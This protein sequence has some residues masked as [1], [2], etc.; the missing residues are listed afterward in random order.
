MSTPAQHPAE[1]PHNAAPA[2]GD[3]ATVPVPA[4]GG[5]GIDIVRSLNR[6]RTVA[7]LAALFIVLA[8]TP[9]AWLKGKPKYGATAVIFVSPRFLANLRDSVE[10][11]LQSDQQYRQYVQQNARTINRFDILVEALR[12]AGSGNPFLLK[13]SEPVEH[14]AERLQ[15]AL[16]I[17]PVPDTYQ[18]AVSLEGDK[19]AGL[20]EL[21]NAVVNRFLAKAKA[22]AFYASDE[23]I[24]NLVSD[25]TRI[26]QDMAAKQ[27]RRL[28]ITQEL[29]VSSFTNNFVNPYDHLLVGAREALAAAR[30]QNIQS[31]AAFAAYDA[32]QRAAGADSLRSLAEQ[33]VARD[34]ALTSLTASQSARRTQLMTAMSGLSPDHPGR[35]AAERE[36]ADLDR[37]REQLH[38]KLLDAAAKTLIDQKNA[39]AYKAARV[40]EKLNAELEQQA[41]KTSWFTRNYQEGIELGSYIDQAQKRIEGIQE[42]IDS[43][44]LEKSAP[45][46]ARMFSPARTP[47]LPEKGG[48][49][50]LLAAVLAFALLTGLLLPAAVDMFDPRLHSPRDL[51]KVLGF[52]PAGWFLEKSQAGPDFARE[53]SLRLA[54]RL[55]QE[56]QARDS[57]I[58]AFTSVKARGGTSTLV[59]DTAAAL[60]SLGVSALAVEANA[61]RADPRY[62]SPG[63]RGLTVVLQGTQDFA[64]AVVPGGA[65]MPDYVPVGDI[66]EQKNLPDIQK[67]IDILRAA[68]EA[69]SIVL[70][71]L[72]P[73]LVSVDAEFIARGADVTVLVIEAGAVMKVELQ[74]AAACLERVGVPAVSAVLN[75][76]ALDAADGF[77]RAA[78]E[79]FRTGT[80]PDTAGWLGRRLWK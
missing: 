64:D 6:H 18:I 3:P 57:H 51:E 8:G 15:G 74:R 34:P 32:K 58:F 48:R 43:L 80:A 55:V 63:D 19:P 47:R 49:R 28:E 26:Q 24:L 13:P 42:R 1:L 38:K 66:G 9:L 11:E 52:A 70:V 35:R 78:R 31:E 56:Q 65:A 60:R 33:D 27:S 30:V 5:A 69:Y 75:R 7:A 29:G 53:Q 37:D 22:E 62:R 77:A 10:H 17:T 14:A 68:K 72:P 40:V 41:S 67:L 59:L 46:F 79:E 20:A 12:D 39:D 61:Y 23:R 2:G 45:G 50:K 21:V 25:R 36:L 54:S 44:S 16:A 71:D 4:P 76:V 73:V